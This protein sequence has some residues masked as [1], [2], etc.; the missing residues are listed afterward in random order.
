MKK[1][2]KK[3]MCFGS[4]DLF[5][6]GHAFFL[7]KS[8]EY[9]DTLI[10]TIARDTNIKKIKGRTPMFS[11]NERLE[12]VKKH[13]PQ[14]KVCLGDPN[15]FYTCIRMYKPDV[16]C[17]GYDQN[18]NEKEIKNLFPFLTIVRIEA[19]RENEFKSSLLK[20][21]LSDFE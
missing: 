6:S 18:A 2:E 1:S 7:S 20:K 3:V 8:L 13:F 19:Y 14:A 5:H 21:K 15:D 11:E 4:F 10:V 12:S 17:L 9:G 16:L